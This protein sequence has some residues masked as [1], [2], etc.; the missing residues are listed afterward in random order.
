MLIFLIVA[1]ILITLAVIFAVQNTVIVTVSFLFW[2]YTGSLAIIL[3]AALCAGALISL[4][5]YLPSLTRDKWTI[6]THKKRLNE[7]EASLADHKSK[8]ED[9][10]QQLQE[11]ETPPEESKPQDEE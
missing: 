7:M 3:L 6:R 1:L 11:K 2:T 10:Q 8:L 9:A 5:F 4:L